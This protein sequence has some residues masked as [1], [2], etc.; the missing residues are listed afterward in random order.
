MDFGS[1]GVIVQARMGSSRLPGKVLKDCHGK[2]ILGWVLDRLA[3]V[4]PNISIVVATSDLPADDAIEEFCRKRSVSFV[5]G[6]E[7]DVLSRFILAA[8]KL[9]RPVLVRVTADCPLI[10]PEVVRNC[11]LRF[12]QSPSRADYLSNVIQRTYPRGL[13]VE[14]FTADALFKADKEAKSS[15]ER[16][17]V[18]PFIYRHPEIFRIDSVAGE[19]DF[20]H[21]RWTLDTAEDFELISKLIG[22][23]LKT[24]AH[25][26]LK[27][28]IE[29]SSKNPEWE[30][31]NLSVEQKAH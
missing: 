12:F 24:G 28:L 11:L 21:H 6:S 7:T 17:H 3:M 5:R 15:G 13:D 10:D 4:D 26:G 29:I 8:Q 19:K 25:F 9:S 18:T 2:P 16:E 30:K 31:I 22:A 20:S 27:E 14:V 1:V 23:G